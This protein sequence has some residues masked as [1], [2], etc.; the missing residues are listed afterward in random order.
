MFFQFVLV[1][2][3]AIITP[4][5]NGVFIIMVCMLKELRQTSNYFF[6]NISLVNISFGFAS[7]I[8][9]GMYYRQLAACT[10]QVCFYREVYVHISATDMALT[11]TI[12]TVISIERYICIFHALRWEQIITRRRV[13]VVLGS[14]WLFWI[15]VPT[16]LRA[17]DLWEIFEILYMIQGV[18]TITTVVITNSI[19]LIARWSVALLSPR[20][21]E[22][23]A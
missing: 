16:S 20:L 5:I 11:M 22:I 1:V 21:Q 9:C 6:L 10:A 12:F 7:L 4:F 17:A 14:L 15:T 19:I 23:S 2:I 3:F 13:V 8:T 18:L